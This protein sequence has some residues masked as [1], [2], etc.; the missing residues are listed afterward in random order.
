MQA[1]PTQINL[2][3]LRLAPNCRDDSVNDDT[4]A[5]GGVQITVTNGD[6]EE[7]VPENGYVEMS[8]TNSSERSKSGLL[9]LN[10]DDCETRRVKTLRPALCR[11]LSHN[12]DLYSW[13]N[14]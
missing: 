6:K 3:S 11:S 14:E 9:A 4:M 10:W 1:C 5:A 13:H 2:P 7:A 8:S 12:C